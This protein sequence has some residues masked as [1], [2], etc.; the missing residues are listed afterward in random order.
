MELMKTTIIVEF[1]LYCF[2][3][4]IV[5]CWNWVATLL[6]FLPANQTD[7]FFERLVLFF[8]AYSNCQPWTSRVVGCWQTTQSRN[9]LVIIKKIIAS[10]IIACAYLQTLH[11]PDSPREIQYFGDWM[12]LSSAC[13]GS[14]SF[15]MLL[16]TLAVANMPSVPVYATQLNAEFSWVEQ[17]VF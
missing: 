12:M 17:K 9:M 5:A 2:K 3:Y 13:G 8:K 14:Q 7:K 11:F 15:T 10:K 6:Q 4:Q 1:K 16:V